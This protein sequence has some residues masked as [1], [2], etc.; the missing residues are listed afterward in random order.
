[1]PV[2]K[3]TLERLENTM[4]KHACYNIEA[5]PKKVKKKE[6]KNLFFLKSRNFDITCMHKRL[7]K[8]PKVTVSIG[9]HYSVMRL[10]SVIFGIALN[11]QSNHASLISISFKSFFNLDKNYLKIITIHSEEGMT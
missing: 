6:N 9:F 4:H 7:S 2:P 11:E 8:M 10:S 3:I 5:V 1:M